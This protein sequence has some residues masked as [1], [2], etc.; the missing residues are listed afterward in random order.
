MAIGRYWVAEFLRLLGGYSLGK[1][2][3]Y[4]AL[5]IQCSCEIREH[6]KPHK[7]RHNESKYGK[8]HRLDR[9]GVPTVVKEAWPQNLTKNV[10]TA[11]IELFASPALY[12]DKNA[13]P[14]SCNIDAESPKWKKGRREIKVRKRNESGDDRKKGRGRLP[15]GFR[16]GGGREKRGKKEIEERKGKRSEWWGEDCGGGEGG[17]RSGL[18]QQ[19]GIGGGEGGG[20][21]LAGGGYPGGYPG[22]AHHHPPHHHHPHPHLLALSAAAA[23]AAAANSP[24]SPPLPPSSDGCQDRLGP[25]SVSISGSES[26]GGDKSQEEGGLLK[27]A[28][29]SGGGEASSGA[30][31]CTPPR[32]RSPAESPPPPLPPP[33]P[34]HLH[35]PA[36]F[37]LLLQAPLLPPSQWLYSQLCPPHPQLPPPLHPRPPSPPP[38][39]ASPKSKTRTS[40]V[41]RPY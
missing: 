20:G 8:S 19:L 9:K 29:K 23:A 6:E 40:D 13:V 3:L 35:H 27:T 34:L 24:A 1:T 5:K 33:P 28:G 37:S 38:G 22:A 12:S 10:N 16:A 14:D 11:T 17:G 30:E 32:G 31:S 25:I 4:K 7:S 39:K 36:F 2:V 21:W 41:W 18:A 15:R 26:P